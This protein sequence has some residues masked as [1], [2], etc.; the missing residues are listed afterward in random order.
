MFD[1][2]GG[3]EQ[4]GRP[5]E[6]PGGGALRR[7]TGRARCRAA[8]RPTAATARP[9][10]AS[11]TATSRRRS[12][13][14]PAERGALRRA[15]LPLQLQLPRRRLPPRGAGRG[16]R[17]ARARRA[18]PHRPRRL[19]R[20]GPLRRGGRASWACPRCSAPSSRSACPRPQNG[21]ADPEGSHLLVLARDPE[22]YAGCA[23]RSAPAQL[24][25][26]EKGRPVY[27]LDELVARHRGPLAGAHRL[28]QGRGAGRRCD[29]TGRRRAAARAATGWSTLFGARQRGRRADRPRRPARRRAQRRARRAGRATPGCRRRR[30]QQRALRHARRGAGWPPRWPRCGPG[31]AWTRS[32]AGCPPAATAHLRS[33]AE[34]AARFA[35]Y[36]GAVARAAALGARAAPSTCSWSRR[37]LPPFPVPARAHRDDASCASSP[38]AGAR[39]ALRQPRAS[40]PEAVRSRSTTSW[41]SSRSWTSPA[42]S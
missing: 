33:G 31:A 35:R 37:K 13:A 12:P 16:G 28:P 8:R 7:A 32:T 4:P 26:E 40:D 6:H 11:A 14:E 29:A 1:L 25:G 18:G 19:L 24:R 21:V 2:R 41:R 23:A 38:G 10:R 20:R 27:D 22:G 30:H 36:P 3:L 15:A 9:G 34:M 42:T 17:P 5:V 39:A